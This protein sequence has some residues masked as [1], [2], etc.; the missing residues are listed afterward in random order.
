DL[1]IIRNSNNNGWT[2]TQV[3]AAGVNV[4]V[5]VNRGGGG[6]LYP[7]GNS[8]LGADIYNATTDANGYYSV[9]FKSNSQ[10]VT[11]WYTFVGFT[12]T[13]DTIV[14]GNTKPGLSGYYWGDTD[15]WGGLV[16][17]QTYETSYNFGSPS[18]TNGNPGNV[19]IGTA[20]VTGTI[21]MSLVL[22][23]APDA[24]TAPVY[25][26]TIMPVPAGI[27][28][29]MSLNK[30]P[31][32]LANKTYTT[33]TDANGRYTFSNFATVANGTTGFTQNG[34]IWVAD[35]IATRDTH[36]VVN[37]IIVNPAKPGK[38]GV[39][40]NNSTNQN[41]LFNNEFRNAADFNFAGHVA[42]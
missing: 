9:N 21:G 41:G 30:D 15:S 18:I 23:T 7:N 24:T 26:S 22:S 37:N 12:G 1:V 13:Q 8:N 36:I 39:Y 31:Y 14:S 2:T 29:Y 3:P 17:G 4:Q 27:T 38:S 6:G 19:D 34:N 25:G 35:Y 28:V 40:G 20:S 32:T 33:T 42:D 16:M 10:G 11:A 5:K